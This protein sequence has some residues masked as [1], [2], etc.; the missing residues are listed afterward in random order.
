MKDDQEKLHKV[1]VPSNKNGGDVIYKMVTCGSKTYKLSVSIPS[2]CKSGD[3]FFFKLPKEVLALADAKSDTNEVRD[4]KVPAKCEEDINT[5]SKSQEKKSSATNVS[6]GGKTIEILQKD[7]IHKSKVGSRKLSQAT[8]ARTNQ[9]TKNN[10][11]TS[12]FRT[13]TAK[14]KL[15]STKNEPSLHKIQFAPTFR[16]SPSEFEDPMEYIKKV[17]K[18]GKKYGIIKIKPPDGWLPPCAISLPSLHREKNLKCFQYHQA[19]A[20][21]QTSKE[22][23]NFASLQ[24]KEKEENR[25]RSQSPILNTKLQKLNVLE[26][27]TRIRHQFLLSFRMYLFKK[28][29]FSVSYYVEHLIKILMPSTAKGQFDVEK[30]GVKEVILYELYDQVRLRIR[31]KL[32]KSPMTYKKLNYSS[33]MHA[34][35]TDVVRDILNSMRV[36]E[37]ETSCRSLTIVDNVFKFYV[38]NLQAFVMFTWPHDL[39]QHYKTNNK[40]GLAQRRNRHDTETLLQ[41]SYKYEDTSD[42]SKMRGPATI[43]YILQK[44]EG[45]QDLSFLKILLQYMN[46]RQ[47]LSRYYYIAR[48]AGNPLNLCKL[49]NE[50][51]K[52]GGVDN[53]IRQSLWRQI[54]LALGITTCT[55]LSY[56]LKQHYNKYLL[57]YAQHVDG[58]SMS[59][60]LQNEHGKSVENNDK[61]VKTL[62]LHNSKRNLQAGGNPITTEAIYADE[63]AISNIDEKISLP[64][65]SEDTQHPAE[66]RIKLT[67]DQQSIPSIPVY[68]TTII[69]LVEDQKKILNITKDKKRDDACDSRKEDCNKK[70]S[71]DIPDILSKV[72]PIKKPLEFK[73]A[74]DSTDRVKREKFSTCESA[75][76]PNLERNG[77]EQCEST[78]DNANM[79]TTEKTEGLSAFRCKSCPQCGQMA[80]SNFQSVC[81]KCKYVFREVARKKEERE[82]IDTAKRKKTCKS[83]RKCGQMANSNIQKKCYQCGHIFETIKRKIDAIENTHINSKKSN[84]NTRRRSARSA[85]KRARSIIKAIAREEIDSGKL[86]K[87]ETATQVHSKKIMNTERRLKRRIKSQDKWIRD[88][89]CGDT[90]LPNMNAERNDCEMK[91][92]S[93]IWKEGGVDY[94][95]CRILG[96]NFWK[97]FPEI[98]DVLLGRVEKYVPHK[99]NGKNSCGV[100]NVTANQAHWVISYGKISD[101]TVSIAKKIQQN[102]ILV[103]SNTATLNKDRTYETISDLSLRYLLASGE[104]EGDAKAANKSG[105]CSGCFGSSFF[106]PFSYVC[107]ECYLCYHECCAPKRSIK[108]KNRSFQYK[109]ISSNARDCEWFC[110]NCLY[111]TKSFGFQRGS[112]T[113][114]KYWQQAKN[115]K[116][117]LFSDEQFNKMYRGINIDVTMRK[118]EE[119]E[120]LYW[121]ILM[122]KMHLNKQDSYSN[123]HPHLNRLGKIRKSIFS[124]Q[125]Q[126]RDRYYYDD[127]SSNKQS[128]HQKLSAIQVIYGNDI[129]T[130]K[131]G[132]GFPRQPYKMLS[133]MKDNVRDLFNRTNQLHLSIAH[134]NY[135]LSKWKF[136]AN[137]KWNLNNIPFLK[138]SLLRLLP[139][140]IPGVTRPWVYFGMCFSTFC[141]HV[142]DHWMYS[143]NYM[144]KGSAK[145]W[146]GVPEASKEQFDNEV[147]SMVPDI[148]DREPKLMHLLLSQVHPGHLAARGV[149]LYKVYQNPGEFIIT[150]PKAYH[151]GF[152]TGFNLGEACNFVLS[153]W[154]DI[155]PTVANEYGKIHRQPVL[156]YQMLLLLAGIL[157][158]SKKVGGHAYL[159]GV[160][161]KLKPIVN[162]LLDCMSC[163]DVHAALTRL[164]C[165]YQEALQGVILQGQSS[166]KLIAHQ[167]SA[168][169]CMESVELSELLD[170]CAVD[171]LALI[172]VLMIVI[173]YW[174]LDPLSAKEETSGN[175]SHQIDRYIKND[176]ERKLLEELK[177]TLSPGTRHC[178]VCKRYCPFAFVTSGQNS[179]SRWCLQH[180]Q[181]ALSCPT[182]S[183]L[184]PATLQVVV[185]PSHLLTLAKCME[186][187]KSSSDNINTPCKE[188]RGLNAT[189][190]SKS[191]IASSY[192]LP[193]N[194]YHSRQQDDKENCK[195]SHIVKLQPMMGKPLGMSIASDDKN[196]HIYVSGFYRDESGKKL[197]AELSDLRINDV[198][199]QVNGTRIESHCHAVS[200]MRGAC[201][202]GDVLELLILDKHNSR[203]KLVGHD[204]NKATNDTKFSSNDNYSKETVSFAR[205]QINN[206][207]WEKCNCKQQKSM[208]STYQG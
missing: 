31:N 160:D 52:R 126:I 54:G 20:C 73:T 136:H 107:Q 205:I 106:I 157:G 43:S 100:T 200:M 175:S 47:K 29:L 102:E 76:I 13:S 40:R 197:V 187:G 25:A 185:H 78:S 10:F 65:K 166:K 170:S 122:Q 114:A 23:Q 66:N 168:N 14:R 116:N 152:S 113:L 3:M 194:T 125:L 51:K 117:E 181:E 109:T 190:K 199:M 127:H 101:S 9:S 201:K 118:I 90:K 45:S 178:A 192:L 179:P 128:Y 41:K 12:N 82:I 186:N 169:F 148:Y 57:D 105:T 195:I 188:R 159:N 26:I 204:T 85:S 68:E 81:K 62:P 143:I 71:E 49:Y 84:N 53:V 22:Y 173:H 103:N 15:K 8:S 124:K 98:D 182:I 130:E 38:K 99:S 177:K 75:K 80:G 162:N 183:D 208:Q 172:R 48:V 202:N 164:I 95:H 33:S 7:K 158:I 83:C 115:F 154:L 111:D 77:I 145:V 88:Y 139:A 1:I 17:C 129:D 150:F 141:W 142:E 32:V 97:Y 163:K 135:H 16:P 92:G 42:P 161:R 70:L 165:E 171:P 89:G 207:E 55:S 131:I 86:H 91:F 132:S 21:K 19:S 34:V 140:H 167:L 87:E 151:G 37:V 50:V 191:N 39:D 146:Y 156:S 176:E 93:G 137:S 121:K 74:V 119:I 6:S 174:Y 104:S 11:G 4:K 123:D 184:N 5:S 27:T 198:I 69:N 133:H 61:K 134:S 193:R 35:W 196:N 44:H 36:K 28:N 110:P 108:R 144:H 79:F 147:K 120:D 189:N 155:A 56:T 138:E 59:T 64:K 63:D 46:S 24:S 58:Q 149:Q 30:L 180:A 206:Y 94:G 112:I 18:I 153:D 203:G 96:R 60:K 67:R 72:A 2:Q